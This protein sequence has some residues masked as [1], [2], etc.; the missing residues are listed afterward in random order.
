M[1]EPVI[2]GV[3]RHMAYSSTLLEEHEVAYGQGAS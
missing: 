2:P 3:D 1:D